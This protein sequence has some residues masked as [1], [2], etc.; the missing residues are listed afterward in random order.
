MNNATCHICKTP[1]ISL[2]QGLLWSAPRLAVGKSTIVKTGKDSLDIT[3]YPSDDLKA[4]ETELLGCLR[5]IGAV[6]FLKFKANPSMVLFGSILISVAIAVVL[7]VLATYE[8]VFKTLLI[9]KELTDWEG[10]VL[11]VTTL[12]VVLG[13]GFFPSILS[14][15]EDSKVKELVRGWYNKEDRVRKRLKY[16]LRILCS[17]EKLSISLWNPCVFQ[18]DSWVWRSL[19]PA[20]LDLNIPITV[21]IKNDEGD[22]FF[23]AI[24]NVD[25]KIEFKQSTV[26]YS[27]TLVEDPP[28]INYKEIQNLLTNSEKLLLEVLFILS[29]YNT[30]A[31]WGG[32]EK[33]VRLRGLISLDLA[34]F[35]V[36][37][38]VGNTAPSGD[39]DAKYLYTFF[40]R[41][42]ADY[43]LILPFVE[44]GDRYWR[45]DEKVATLLQ[46]ETIRQRHQYIQ[47]YL[48]TEWF[49]VVQ[50]ISDPVGLLIVFALLDSNRSPIKLKVNV[51]AAM[52][53][54]AR[55]SESY[56]LMDYFGTIKES[57]TSSALGFDPTDFLRM[58]PIPVLQQLIPLLE[59]AGYF[60]DALVVADFLR[61]ISSNAYDFIIAGI[62][63]RLGQY[64]N[65]LE[66]LKRLNKSAKATSTMDINQAIGFDLKF[67]LLASWI[68]VSGRLVEEKETGKSCLQQAQD[69]FTKSSCDGKN[70]DP[71]DLWHYHNNL[72]QYFEWEEDFTACID[73]HL[74]CQK[75]P[76]IELKWVSG[77]YVNLGVAYRER[78]KKGKITDDLDR[79]L[80][81]GSKGVQIKRELGDNDE[82]PVA[83]HNLALSQ[84]YSFKCSGDQPV[85]KAAREN[86]TDGLALLRAT[87][88]VKKK[89]TLLVEALVAE[90]LL[91]NDNAVRSLSSEFLLWKSNDP[92]PGDA[93][94]AA[95]ILEALEVK[96]ES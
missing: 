15:A 56:F 87:R 25:N 69:A 30:P 66:L 62:L 8:D 60:Q 93:A 5:R 32:N 36:S 21:H 91:G 64:Q 70:C 9:K 73:N 49:E 68:I 3:L 79:A 89:G 14:S 55:G 82:L 17:S 57:Y 13:I 20:I 52:I 74:I 58:L 4:L 46:M 24:R 48:E 80:A 84:L 76:G 29:T 28:H 95:G 83:L 90:K 81:F 86:A 10:G 61:P 72:A 33:I 1:P 67:S 59:R 23:V 37:R 50:N 42:I 26:E 51:L 38:Y 41:C 43:R 40:R 65:A 39:I 92:N 12:F 71:T 63:E 54:R 35:A 78:F 88:S 22:A 31:I 18:E 77:T 45:L 11:G 19:V 27:S 2:Y 47:N 7:G 6:P 75:L 53:E 96:C 16:A 94:V 85:L 34:S 44:G